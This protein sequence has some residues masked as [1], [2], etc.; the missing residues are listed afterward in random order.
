[1]HNFI[2]MESSACIMHDDH[3]TNSNT[4]FIFILKIYHTMLSFVALHCGGRIAVRI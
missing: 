1:M 3:F 2:D 4:Q